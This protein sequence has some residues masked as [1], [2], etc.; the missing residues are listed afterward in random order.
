MTNKILLQEFVAAEKLR[1]LQSIDLFFDGQP[2]SEES[3]YEEI[4]DLITAP[5]VEDKELF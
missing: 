1:G 2:T 5:E 3:A 4:V